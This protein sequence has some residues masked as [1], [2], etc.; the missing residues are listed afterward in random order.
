M[1][2]GWVSCMGIGQPFDLHV[3]QTLHC[4]LFVSERR[5]EQKKNFEDLIKKKQNS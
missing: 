3:P 4:E 2:D 5:K 1:A